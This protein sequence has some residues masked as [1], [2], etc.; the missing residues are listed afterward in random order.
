MLEDPKA[1]SHYMG[2]TVS[3]PEPPYVNV[4]MRSQAAIPDI[5]EGLK[6]E[7]KRVSM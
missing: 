5:V 3:E 4:R 7:D 6:T 2:P 1:A